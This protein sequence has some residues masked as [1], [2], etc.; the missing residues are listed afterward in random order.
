MS[1]SAA[2]P[3]KTRAERFKSY[4]DLAAELNNNPNANPAQILTRLFNGFTNEFSKAEMEILELE[5]ANAQ[6]QQNLE[7]IR[8][9]HEASLIPVS[10]NHHACKH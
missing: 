7:T 10:W 2:E 3:R 8:L 5:S 9:A 4:S 1:S 6:L